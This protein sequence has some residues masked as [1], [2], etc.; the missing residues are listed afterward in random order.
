MK[1]LKLSGTP[2]RGC[3][4]FNTIST[5]GCTAFTLGYNAVTP[6][7]CG[8]LH[9]RFAECSSSHPIRVWI[10]SC[11]FCRMLFLTPFGCGFLHVRFAECSSSHP[12]GVDS[13]MFVLPNALPHTRFGCGFLHVRFAECSSSHPKGVTAL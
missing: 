13:F 11:S 5:Q 4:G 9:V 3:V 10:P 6:F 1:K 8:F 2:L 7:G 12:S